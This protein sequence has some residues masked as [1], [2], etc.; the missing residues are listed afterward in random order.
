MLGGRMAK[1]AGSKTIIPEQ[2]YPNMVKYM[3]NEAR[4]RGDKWVE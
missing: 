1:A 2:A 3:A 4:E